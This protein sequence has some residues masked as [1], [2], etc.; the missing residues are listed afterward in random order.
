MKAGGK[1]M[2]DTS[3]EIM[4]KRPQMQGIHAFKKQQRVQIKLDRMDSGQVIWRAR[5]G[6]LST[7]KTKKHARGSPIFFRELEELLRGGA[8]ARV[9]WTLRLSGHCRQ[10]SCA[11]SKISCEPYLAKTQIDFNA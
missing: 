8:F 9:S 11:S 1:F 7:A 6:L 2:I 10:C 5:K 3:A 4:M